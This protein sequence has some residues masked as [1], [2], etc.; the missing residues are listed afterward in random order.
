MELTNQRVFIFGGTSGFGYALARAVLAQGARVII[1]G[2]SKD[3]LNQALDSLA[4]KGQVQGF[5]ADTADRSEIE[6]LFAKLGQF[7]H[8]VS[9]AGGF[10]PGSFLT[11]PEADVRAAVD[12]KLFV[13]MILARLC[14]PH[15][16][17]G[18]SI[19]FTAGADGTPVEAAGAYVGNAAIRTLVQGLAAEL[20][21]GIRVN[22]VAPIWT[23]TGLWRDL[24][25]AQVAQM[26]EHLTQTIPLKRVA[27]VDEVADAY[28]FLMKNTFMT[29]QT[30][31][32]DGG[33]S[34]PR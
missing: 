19:V 12:E 6:E 21:P 33:L 7:D 34:I 3:R 2:R 25:K 27:T 16:S 11:G 18:G 5:I 13:N 10:T 9:L 15:L 14:A 26:R 17:S 23:P 30:I 8:F 28:C 29:G 32:I 24:P 20:A 22:A 4:P 1:T 31:N